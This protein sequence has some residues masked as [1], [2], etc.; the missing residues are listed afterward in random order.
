M[1]K[2]RHVAASGL[3]CSALVFTAGAIPTLGGAGNALASL[4]LTI[5]AVV[6]AEGIASARNRR[7]D[8]GIWVLLAA[9]LP[10]LGVLYAIGRAILLAA[11][12]PIAGGLLIGVATVIAATTA[13][14]TLKSE[15]HA[16]R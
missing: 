5:A 16:S 7:W 8:F 2:S 9:A 12:A 15:R 3:T 4:L 13:F 1:T 11:G 14:A 6:G 10:L